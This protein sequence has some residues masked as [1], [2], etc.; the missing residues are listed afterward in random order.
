MAWRGWGGDP[1][2]SQDQR[3]P[4]GSVQGPRGGECGEPP[5]YLNDMQLPPC[6]AC[7]LST[8]TL[9]GGGSQASQGP[10]RLI[11]LPGLIQAQRRPRSWE[12]GPGR[13]VG[14]LT[15]RRGCRGP[16][17]PHQAIR[18]LIGF[19]DLSGPAFPGPECSLRTFEDLTKVLSGSSDGAKCKEKEMAPSPRAPPAPRPMAIIWD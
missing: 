11:C 3:K 7:N 12:G 16:A 9:D 8:R 5:P 14:V 1:Q 15:W 19:P 18:G 2:V 4:P 10:Q 17:N 6:P 13:V